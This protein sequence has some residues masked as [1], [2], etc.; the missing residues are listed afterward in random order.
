MRKQYSVFFS[1]LSTVVLFTG[2][3]VRWE[4]GVV[5]PSKKEKLDRS[6]HKVYLDDSSTTKKQAMMFSELKEFFRKGIE[7]PRTVRL[8]EGYNKN[9]RIEKSENFLN[10]ASKNYELAINNFSRKDFVEILKFIKVIETDKSK[11]VLNF[12]EEN[13]KLISEKKYN[14]NFEIM[15]D[16]VALAYIHQTKELNYLERK[17]GSSYF[18]IDGNEMRNNKRLVLIPAMNFFSIKDKVTS[19]LKTYGFNIVNKKEDASDIIKLETVLLTTIKNLKKYKYR[20][21]L[22]TDKSLKDLKTPVELSDISMNLGSSMGASN[23]SSAIIGLA[24]FALGMIDNNTNEDSLV[25]LIY[26]KRK[27]D[28]ETRILEIEPRFF[29]NFYQM[30]YHFQK[31]NFDGYKDKAFE[32][33]SNSIKYFIEDGLS[34]NTRNKLIWLKDK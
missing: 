8:V 22:L 27:Y 25:M 5:V 12:N 23:N 28:G 24:A 14:N 19:Q 20:S 4:N 9:Y 1:I 11:I 31:K 3:G 30:N 33:V 34:H 16:I 15:K 13:G 32:H 26:A 6:E 17:Y 21:E 29:R 10:S 18:V 7:I 2:C